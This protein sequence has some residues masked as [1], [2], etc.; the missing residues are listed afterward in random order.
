MHTNFASSPSLLGAEI[1]ELHLQ[2]N[3]KQNNLFKESNLMLTRPR[4]I[5]SNESERASILTRLERRMHRISKAI[6]KLTT[7]SGN[8][9]RIL[10]GCI[11]LSLDGS[12]ETR[13]TCLLPI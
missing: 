12:K 6:A 2:C 5:T 3:N 13:V 7:A 4:T 10:R 9:A 11:M 8:E 1:D